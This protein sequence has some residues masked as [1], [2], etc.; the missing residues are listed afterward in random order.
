MDRD[1]RK[2]R[3]EDKVSPETLIQDIKG[4]ADLGLIKNYGV[5]NSLFSKLQNADRL[6][7]LGRLKET[8]NIVKAFGHDLSAQKGRHI[9]EKCVSAAQTD[10]D[11]FMGV[12]TVQE[13]LKRY[14][15]E[16]R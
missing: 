13:S 15:I 11:F 1:C 14:L 10:M 9:D 16:K 12:N 4:C 6:Y 8:Q 7:R 2:V 3:I 5:L